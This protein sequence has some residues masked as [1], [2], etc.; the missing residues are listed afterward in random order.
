M[1]SPNPRVKPRLEAPLTRCQEALVRL[2]LKWAT[3]LILFGWCRAALRPDW[4]HGNG[5]ADGTI[6]WVEE[7]APV[8]RGGHFDR[9]RHPGFPRAGW[10]LEAAAAGLLP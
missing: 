8:H 10:G 9:Q 1:N 7:D 6:A 4:R 2:V 3:Q 5:K